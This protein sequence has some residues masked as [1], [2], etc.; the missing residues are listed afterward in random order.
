MID[1]NNI[2][3]S[4]K[5]PD[6]YGESSSIVDL[7]ATNSVQVKLSGELENEHPTFP[8][9]FVK[10]YQPAYKEFFPLRNPTPLTVNTSGTE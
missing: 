6:S 3:G 1:F 9:S 4:K 2:K 10:A 8:V 5:L 7:H